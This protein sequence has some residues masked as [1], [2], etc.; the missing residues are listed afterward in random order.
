MSLL[1]AGGLVLLCGWCRLIFPSS[2]SPLS[3]MTL[4]DY[5]PGHATEPTDLDQRFMK[6]ALALARTLPSRTWP[7]PPVGALVVKDGLVVGRG[8]H[9]GPGRPHAE[10]MA[11][12]SAGDQARGATLYVTLEPCNHQGRTPACAPRVTAAGITRVVG[13]MRD[14]NPTVAGGGF[15]WLHDQG[16]EVY[17]GVLAGEALD[18]VWPFIVSEN[19]ARPFVELKTATS[20][21]GFFAPAAHKGNEGRP[22]YLTGEQALT[23]VHK[24]RRWVDLV[25]VGAGTARADRPRL[26][27]RRVLGR[28]D[29]P[30]VEPQ[31]GYLDTD[32]SWDGGLDRDSYLVFAGES[33]AGKAHSR[34]LGTD[35]GCVIGCS[36]RDGKIDLPDLLRRLPGLDVHVLMVEGGPRLAASFLK[37]GLVDRWVRYEAPV[38]VQDGVGWPAGESG[39]EPRLLGFTR[40]RSAALGSDQVTI[41]DRNDFAAT[42]GR[43]AAWEVG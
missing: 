14:P 20:S 42:L 40:T 19:F 33:A 12:Q 28:T 41:W 38:A 31:A 30:Q 4:A 22:F 37:A 43:V 3:N 34:S 39:L 6:E 23:D 9:F 21:D 5:H 29:L 2:S 32:R 35:G 10:I 25:L 1:S 13:A 36:Q 17:C 27:G 11:L 26:D 24:R 15:A 7:N 18:L 16:V 8:C